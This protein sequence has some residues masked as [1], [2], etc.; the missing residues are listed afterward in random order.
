MEKLV[1]EKFEK[2]LYKLVFEYRF[3]IV[4]ILLVFLFFN[5]ISHLPYLNLLLNSDMIL[6]IL[7]VLCVLVFSIK[8]SN[9]YRIGIFLFLPAFLFYLL[10]RMVSVEFIG[11]CIYVLFITGTVKGILKEM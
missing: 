5:S 9:I 4:F 1:A 7:L 6:I 10:D 2:K 3:K 8:I 11:N